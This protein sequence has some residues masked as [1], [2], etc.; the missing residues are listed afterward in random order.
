MP[1]EEGRELFYCRVTG[2][3]LPLRSTHLIANI[4]KVPF[5]K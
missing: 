3:V 2:S 4:A 5:I 1:V